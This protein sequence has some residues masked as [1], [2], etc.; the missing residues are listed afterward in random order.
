M[1]HLSNSRT[2]F[3]V[4]LI[5]LALC[6]F[7]EAAGPTRVFVSV[8]GEQRIAVYDLSPESGELRGVSSLTTVGEPGALAVSP[9]RRFLLAAI[10]SRGELASFR[11]DPQSGSLTLVS[12]VPAGADPA[13]VATDRSG[14]FLLC[15]YYVAGKVTVHALDDQGKISPEPVQTQATD[16]KAHAVLADSTNL[17]VFV[18]HTGP[19]AIHQFH[20]D[21]TNG[22]LTPN[23]V[24][25]VTTGDNTGPRHL[26]FH[27]TLDMVF[28]DNEQGSSVTSYRLD[29]KTG[30]LHP[31]Q[32]LSTLPEGYAQSNSC[33]R[34]KIAPGG[35]FLYAAN[36]GHD[37]LAGFRIDESTGEMAAIGQFQTEATPR[38]FDIDPSGTFLIAA[39]QSSD[40]LATFRIDR[41]TGELTRLATVEVGKTPWWVEI[42]DLPDDQR[43]SAV[44]REW[45]TWMGSRFDGISTEND[46]SPLWPSEGLRKVWTRQ[47]G[48]GFSSVALAEGRLY[49]LG[50]RDGEETVYCL[51]ADTGEL[52]WSQT[53][54]SEL[55]DNLHEGGPAATPTIDRGLVY[56][57]GKEGQLYC[58]RADTGDVVWHK[59]LTKEFAVAVPE[60]GFSGTPRIFGDRLIIEGGRTA[61][62]HRIT[63]EKLWQT[64]THDAG[65]GSVAPFPQGDQLLLAVL[66]CEGLRV[67]DST[68]GRELAFAEWPSPFRT[69]STTPIVQG[70]R[71][72]ISTAYNVGCGLFRW[73][74]ESLESIYQN[75]NM[76]NHFNNSILYEGHLYGFDGNSNLGRVVQLTCIDFLTGEMK[77]QQAGFGC[78]SL[79]IADGK[80]LILSDSGTLVLAEATPDGYRELARSPFLS[81]RC[82]T[83]P[84]L[85][86]GRIY[87]RSAAG[88][89]TC[90]EL[91]AR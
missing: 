13:F 29:R 73:T 77:W 41:T 44:H 87:G 32:T 49:T 54:P 61:A 80:L 91:P 72:F 67:L 15:A 7:A 42:T 68:D 81:G 60:W 21:G 30:R 34:L 63:G 43:T 56:T 16:D 89:L 9:D 22:R 84:I 11:I 35:R 23:E 27:P 17:L 40:K 4:A 52:L 50:H 18:P 57:L 38:G 24:P 6:G 37:S 58:F 51:N 1:R 66:D 2:R 19:N 82:W 65:Y 83:V 79:M 71:I 14:K 53:Y 20:F 33:A 10:R 47:I 88:T 12:Q 48:I 59:E 55:N 85:V 36:R 74:G 86:G 26:Q 45:P 69:N 46:W 64:E 78:G 28:F 31:E 5:C 76:R 25:V 75:R 39:G 3:V 90:V 8:A 62:F 70:D